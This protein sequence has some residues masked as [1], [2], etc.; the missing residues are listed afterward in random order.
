PINPQR[1]A[2]EMRK[3]LPDKCILTA[4]SG[5]STNWW[6]RQ[7]KLRKGMEASLSGTL[8]TMGPATPYAIAARFAFPDRPVIATVGDGAFQ[9]NG[10]NEM[11]TI[12]RYMERLMAKRQPFIFCIF[13]NQDLN[14]VTWEQRVMAGD[15][16]FI[17][18]QYI[19]DVP[20]AKYA[21]LLGLKGI[22][23][24][25]ADQV[26]A[27]WDEALSTT[28][29]PVVMDVKVDPEIPPLPPHIRLDQAKHM[30]SAMMGDEPERW[31]AIKKS[32]KGKAAEFKHALKSHSDDS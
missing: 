3:R 14:Q 11:I 18:S 31:G 8:A 20:F 16:K 2:W 6:A 13:N 12:K 7:L 22:Y 21:E 9:M 29:R 24:D 32:L 25:K 5:S 27:A 15:P 30:M 19:P 28:D 26:G 23:C 17:G 10:M 1:V 4:D